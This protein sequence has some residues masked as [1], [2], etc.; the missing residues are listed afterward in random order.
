MKVIDVFGGGQALLDR[1]DVSIDNRSHPLH[2][3]LVAHALDLGVDAKGLSVFHR[4]NESGR[5]HHDLGRDAPSRETDPSRF[6][7]VDDRD[8]DLG[9]LLNQRVNEVHPGPGAKDD[10]IVFLHGNPLPASTFQEKHCATRC[11]TAAHSGHP[12]DEC[13]SLEQRA[14]KTLNRPRTHLSSWRNSTDRSFENSSHRCSIRCASTRGPN[15]PIRENTGTTT[16]PVCTCASSAGESSLPRR[17]S[18]TPGRA[19]R[20]SGRRPR[21]EA[22]GTKKIAACSC[23]GPRS[24]A[25]TAVRTWDTCSTTAPSRPGPGVASTPPPSNSGQVRPSPVENRSATIE[26]S[27]P[28]L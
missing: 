7:L 5:V 12:F 17:P 15:V 21:K 2:D 4:P 23:G 3:L 14:A 22:W 25:R 13:E 1:V 6:V 8:P 26:G 18:S 11:S 27:P 28:I 16:S 20:A 9:I 24:S 19:G 10:E